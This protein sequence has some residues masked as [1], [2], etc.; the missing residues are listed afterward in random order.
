VTCP[1]QAS[2]VN[3]VRSPFAETC[4]TIAK[5]AP[6]HVTVIDGPTRCAAKRGSKGRVLAVRCAMIT[7]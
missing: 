5:L 7:P 4:A 2:T 6:D 3:V 1:P